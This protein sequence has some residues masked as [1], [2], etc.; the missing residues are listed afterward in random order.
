MVSG[1]VLLH[2]GQV[3]D[4]GVAVRVRKSC[5]V[6]HV[7][8]GLTAPFLVHCIRIR[9]HYSRIKS[10]HTAQRFLIIPPLRSPSQ[11]PPMASSSSNFQSIFNASLEAYNSK[12]KNNL[13]THPLASQ[14]QSCNS[15]NAVLSVLQD[16][17]DQHC[18]N[19]ERLRNWLN[20][21]VNVLYTFSDTLGQGTSLV[22]LNS[23]SLCKLCSDC[24]LS[25]IPAWQSD[26][27]WYRSP[28]LGERPRLFSY[29][30]PS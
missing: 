5:Y 30:R 29:Y 24:H 17:F 2:A 4:S 14:L 15:P 22:S 12:T 16:Q 26:I 27:Y 13:L 23:P 19:N 28:S 7:G 9:F 18:T 3:S 8:C 25:G 21:T 1:G 20:P 10:L 6:S 11:I